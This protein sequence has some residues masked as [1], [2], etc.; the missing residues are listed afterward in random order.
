MAIYMILLF[1]VA[2]SQLQYAQCYCS[3]YH[4]MRVLSHF[5]PDMVS[6][7]SCM[8]EEEVS[9]YLYQ[10]MVFVLYCVYSSFSR[11]FHNQ[12]CIGAEHDR[13]W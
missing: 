13:F 7:C 10:R 12:D 3:D 9:E 6:I 8:S 2:A 1:L 11:L 4:G 5:P